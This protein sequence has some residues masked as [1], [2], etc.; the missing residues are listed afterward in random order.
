MR[1][2]LEG[3]CRALGT[4]ALLHLYI[5]SSVA[6][7]IG[8]ACSRDGRIGKENGYQRPRRGAV[9][10]ETVR[11]AQQNQERTEEQDKVE[12]QQHTTTTEPLTDHVERRD[13]TGRSHDTN[14]STTHLTLPRPPPAHTHSSQSTTR[15]LTPSRPSSKETLLHLIALTRSWLPPSD[16]HP[17]RARPQK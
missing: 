17:V 4:T 14:T 8:E 5:V 12:E 7:L 3:G 9:Q 15:R 10:Q 2:A 16:L 6:V 1:V 11:R 13:P